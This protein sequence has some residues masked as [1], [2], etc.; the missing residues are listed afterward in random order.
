MG[1]DNYRLLESP[2]KAGGFPMIITVKQS[3]LALYALC[4]KTKRSGETCSGSSRPN[5]RGGF[6]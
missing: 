3:I 6:Y 1:S 5:V 2:G 4:M